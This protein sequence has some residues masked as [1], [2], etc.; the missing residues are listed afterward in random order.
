MELELLRAAELRYFPEQGDE[1]VTTLA[2]PGPT[3]AEAEG[4]GQGKSR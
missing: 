1:A 3:S 2:D 4:R